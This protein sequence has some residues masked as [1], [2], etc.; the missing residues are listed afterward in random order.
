MTTRYSITTV[1]G[2]V[3]EAE[4]ILVQ[5][6]KAGVEAQIENAVCLWGGEGK[7]PASDKL[8]PHHSLFNVVSMTR[9]LPENQ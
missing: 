8:H 2:S 5:Q 7:P 3:W 4:V 9:V 6:T 1:T